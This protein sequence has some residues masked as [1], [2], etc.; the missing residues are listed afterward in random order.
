MNLIKPKKLEQGSTISIIA[1][2]GN[3]DQEKLELGINYLKNLGYRVKLGKNLFNQNKYLAG[4]DDERAFDIN[5]AFADTEVDAIICARGGYGAI[6]LIEKLDFSI[7][8]NNPKIFCGYSDITALSSIIFKN[9][10]LITF[11]GPMIQSDF[12][13]KNIN[14]FTSKNLW[15]ALKS[16][17]I[18]ISPN[19]EK[20]YSKGF[21]SGITIGGNLATIASL[22]GINFIP[23]EKFI[24]FVEDINEATYKIDKY[25]RQLLNI[26]EFKNNISAILLGDFIGIDNNVW[27]DDLFKELSKELKIPVISGYPISHGAN[28][29][30]VPYGARATLNE[31]GTLEIIY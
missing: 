18:T 20:F 30:T 29:A 31:N 8:K 7:I 23:D 13:K 26:P 11:S 6:R 24:F 27:L 4:T 10:G 1:P 5:Q 28:K 14:S 25:F 15:K 19:N 22:A 9:T 21:A 12:S 3:V 2:S 16:N 17:K